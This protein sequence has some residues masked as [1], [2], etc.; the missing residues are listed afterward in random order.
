MSEREKKDTVPQML[1]L[2]EVAELLAVDQ[3]TVTRMVRS[4]QLPRYRIGEGSL[5][6]KA[7]DVAALINPAAPS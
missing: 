2:R 4:G 7:S 5:R 3:S 1:R 6:F